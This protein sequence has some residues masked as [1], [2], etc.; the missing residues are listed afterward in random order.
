M[1]TLRSTCLALLAWLGLLSCARGPAPDPLAN[2]P[3]DARVVLGLAPLPASKQA[4]FAFLFNF[5][6]MD[7]AVDWLQTRFGLDPQGDTEGER[8]GLSL[9][10]PLALVLRGSFWVLVLPL[11]DPGCFGER[12]AERLAGNGFEPAGEGLWKRGRRAVAGRVVGR[13]AWV[14]SGAADSAGFMASELQ[15]AASGAR[16]ATLGLP[17]GATAVVRG[18]WADLMGSLDPLAALGSVP[19]WLKSALYGFGELS[20]QL[21]LGADGLKLG[22]SLGAGDNALVLRALKGAAPAPLEALYTGLGF[23]PAALLVARLDPAALGSFAPAWLA[24]WWDGGLAA[25]AG[26]PESPGRLIKRL[27]EH[28]ERFPVEELPWAVLAG[29]RERGGSLANLLDSLS[30]PLS[31]FVPFPVRWEDRGLRIASPARGR[32][33]EAPAGQAAPADLA[34]RPL[35]A[36]SLSVS[37]RALYE[38]LRDTDLFP[39]A[40]TLLSGPRRLTLDLTPE[41]DALRLDLELT[42]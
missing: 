4:A 18:R 7:G 33:P 35:A 19:L 21:T 22:A 28:P 15:A 3:P 20:A 1:T 31:L 39:Y 11:D 27:M 34:P 10:A 29:S 40:L 5:P 36:L 42:L 32:A 37:F 23:Q 13:L 9:E 8:L 41:G 26:L 38:G 25:A 17:P 6:G 12:L 30:A 24:S 16:G 14:T 2:L